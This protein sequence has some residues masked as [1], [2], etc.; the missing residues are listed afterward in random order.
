MNGMKTS[1][2]YFTSAWPVLLLLAAVLL[3]TA[4]VLWLMNQAIGNQRVIVRDKLGDAYRTQLSLARDRL[5]AEWA[6]TSRGL[7]STGAGG[8][9]FFRI[10]TSG[11]ADSAIILDASGAPVYP[12]QVRAPSADP[13]LAD[14][15]WARAR[16]LEEHDPGA[17]ADVFSALARAQGNSVGSAR[18]R[19]AAARCLVQSGQGARAAEL[20]LD[21]LT[22][23]A[24]DLQGRVIQAD[25]L[26]MA[27]HFL[28]PGSPRYLP[29][30]RRMHDLLIDYSNPEM[31]S[32]QRRFIIDEMRSMK[33]PAELLNFPTLEAEQL[34][35][36]L[37]EAEP[38]LRAEPALRL[39]AIPGVWKLGSANGRVV[40][41]FRTAKVQALSRAALAQALGSD[42]NV[43]ALLPNTKIIKA[44]AFTQSTSA[45][46]RTPGWQLVLSPQGRDPFEEL[47]SRQM[48]LYIWI[49]SLLLA[50]VAV[51]AAAAAHFIRRSVRLAGMK[52]DLVAAVSHEL[53]TP[54]SSM[55]LLVDTLLEEPVFDPAKTREYLELIAREN[56]RLSLLIAN[57]LAFSRIERNRYTFEFAPA[58]VEEIVQAAIEAAGERF[59]EPGCELSIDIAPDLPE[60]NADL[61]ALVTTLVNLLDNA[62]KYTPGP[63]EITLRVFAASRGICF[64]VRDN[65]IGIAPREMKKIFLKFYQADGTLARTGGG[66]G[67]GLSIVWF[68]VEA[69]GGSVR[70]SSEPGKGSI[71][72]V[73]VGAA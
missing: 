6:A 38:K 48:T 31:P 65:G 68:L 17:A 18:A 4:V 67:L 20:V 69:H 62:Y 46:E 23:R 9:A 40:A 14:P 63:K 33:L 43:E 50:A 64:E 7:D 57:F 29:A 47:A 15:A 44:G 21:H 5:D 32:A 37:L 52:A 34:A 3:P 60:V 72:T 54:L 66:C 36:Q 19:Q 11:L 59:R 42:V 10:V 2:G 61:S 24:T 35:E 53:K 30:V 8:A 56:S 71:F 70:V 27:I 39:S 49:G 41:L 51:L 28:K 16:R 13:T 1:G 73:A 12:M 22:G 26:L 45:G 25:A 55:Q 58:P